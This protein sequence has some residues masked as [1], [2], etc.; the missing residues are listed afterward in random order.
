MRYDRR[1]SLSPSGSAVANTV[2]FLL[3]ILITR[4][5]DVRSNKR[6]VQLYMLEVA[7]IMLRNN[8]VISVMI[9][10]SLVGL[11]QFH[12]SSEVFVDI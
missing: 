6:P 5:S 8:I 10:H 1:V 7:E 3:A 4:S 9:S 12:A 11:P 2:T